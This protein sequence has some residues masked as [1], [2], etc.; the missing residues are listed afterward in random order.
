MRPSTYCRS[1]TLRLS[2]LDLQGLVEHQH[3]QALVLAGVDISQLPPVE[4]F[5]IGLGALTG[6]FQFRW[7]TLIC[8][9]QS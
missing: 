8:D 6:F 2:G 9:E 4:L 1:A 7:L 3:L 5:K